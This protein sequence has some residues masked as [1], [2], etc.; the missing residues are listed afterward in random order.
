MAVTIGNLVDSALAEVYGHTATVDRTTYLTSAIDAD[1]L[2]VHVADASNFAR[3][4]VEI[5]DELMMVDSVDRSNNTLGLGTVLGRG[6]RGTT[7]ASHA[8]GDRVTMA[9]SIP[10]SAAARAVEEVIRSSGLFAVTSANITFSPATAGYA[11]SSACRQVLSVVWYPPVGGAWVPVRRWTHDRFNHLL[12][13]TD[14]VIPGSTVKVTYAVDPTVPAQAQDFTVTGLPDSCI[15]VIRYGA[16]WKM[17]SF[18]EPATLTAE[19]AEAAAMKRGNYPTSRLKVS[20]YYYQMYR[21][22]L[23]EEMRLLQLNYP[24]LVHFSA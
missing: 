3:G 16:A 13:I 2:T 4:L 22:R 23:D 15:D 21:A 20:Q 10:R 17:V 19:S 1:D 24:I 11:I 7:A 9:P 5:G 6:I 14:A 8:I 18:L 12:V